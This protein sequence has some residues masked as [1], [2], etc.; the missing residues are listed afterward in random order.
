VNKPVRADYLDQVVWDHI[1]G[2][3]ADPHLIRAEID[4]RLHQA[5]TA[6][7]ATKPANVSNSRWPRQP[8]RS[9]G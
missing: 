2:L 8:P 7:P 4:K 6:D 1:T 3:L 5:R 9:P